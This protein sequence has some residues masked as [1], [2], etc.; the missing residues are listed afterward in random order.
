MPGTR[1]GGLKAKDKNL[2][3]YGVDFYA[4]IGAEG[5]KKG[6]TGGFAST[7]RGKDGLTGKERARKWGSTGGRKSRR[8]K[9]DGKT[10]T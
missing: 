5:G 10:T 9:A 8:G 4:R 7:E 3:L 6:R 1:A 2:E